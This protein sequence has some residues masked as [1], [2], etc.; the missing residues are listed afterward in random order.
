MLKRWLI[1]IV[2]SFV[3]TLFAYATYG[4]N[5]R[6]VI[7]YVVL[8]AIQYAALF[9]MAGAAHLGLRVHGLRSRFAE[10]LRLFSAVM[11]PIAPLLTLVSLPGV[12]RTTLPRTL[13]DLYSRFSTLDDTALSTV[14]AVLHPIVVAAALFVFGVF[15]V[16]VIAHYGFEPRRAVRAIA[17]GV[18]VLA[19]L[20]AIVAPLW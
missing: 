6:N 17:F 18:A 3:V 12:Q 9:V 4:F 14:V 20:A 10:T 1:S 16:R 5:R 11:I 19:P 13:A 15:I 2:L 8:I 7:I